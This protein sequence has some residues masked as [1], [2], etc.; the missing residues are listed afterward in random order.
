M[1]SSRSSSGSGSASDGFGRVRAVAMDVDG[2]LTDGS[3]VWGTDGTEFKRF[4]F[5]DITGIALARSSGLAIALISGES[6]AAG[7]LLVGRLADKLGIT[8]V[9]KACHDKA[10]ALRSF[11]SA[12]AV[13]LDEVCYIGDD[14][15]DL[16]AMEIAGLSVAPANAHPSVKNLANYVAAASG[17]QGVAREILDLIVDGQGRSR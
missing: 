13:G 1:V 12:H 5:A 9:Y 8:D 3:F 6:S 4:C 2:V 7:Q 17:G 16:P 10:A 15:I 14:V 11:A